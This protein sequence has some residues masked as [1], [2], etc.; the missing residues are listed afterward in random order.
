MTSTIW[1]LVADGIQQSN[2]DEIHS[3]YI[4]DFMTQ[5]KSQSLSLH[6]TSKNFWLWLIC[7][8]NKGN[9]IN[10]KLTTKKKALL[11]YQNANIFIKKVLFIFISKKNSVSVS[12][13]YF[14]RHKY[15]SCL[16]E[17]GSFNTYLRWRQHLFTILLLSSGLR[18]EEE[19]GRLRTNV[20]LLT[21][22]LFPTHILSYLASPL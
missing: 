5:P 2:M 14:S 11:L 4:L 22:L 18:G 20:S 16:K 17:D 9:T 15:W 19:W 3:K 21:S 7:C 13:K 10:L 1:P 6:V 8:N 12:F